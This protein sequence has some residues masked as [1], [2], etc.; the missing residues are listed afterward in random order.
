MSLMY[1]DNDMEVFTCKEVPASVR[2][3]PL[4]REGGVLLSTYLTCYNVYT[5][6]SMYRL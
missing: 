2:E 5:Y 6:T 1:N 3:V 4:H